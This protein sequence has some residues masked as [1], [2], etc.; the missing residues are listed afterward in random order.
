M[1]TFP[2]I[3]VKI[4]NIWNHHPVVGIQHMCFMDLVGWIPL[5]VLVGNFFGQAERVYRIGM[6]LPTTGND[7]KHDMAIPG[8]KKTHGFVKLDI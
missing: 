7:M 6:V 3:G 8:S 1:G 4:K 2:Q 5:T